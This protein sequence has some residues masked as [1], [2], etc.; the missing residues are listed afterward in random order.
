MFLHYCQYRQKEISLPI[1]TIDIYPIDIC[2]LLLLLLAIIR[3][4]VVK[5]TE[6]ATGMEA[7]FKGLLAILSAL[8]LLIAIK[9]IVQNSINTSSIR[10]LIMMSTG[11]LFAIFFPIFIVTLKDIKNFIIAGIL[12]LLSDIF[13][14]FVLFYIAWLSTSYHLRKFS[15]I[16]WD[17]IFFYNRR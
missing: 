6:F 1:G 12:F 14:A 8:I 5:K 4:F 7:A 17:N 3:I 15:H 10:I 13:T 11:Y 16:Y 9:I 2:F